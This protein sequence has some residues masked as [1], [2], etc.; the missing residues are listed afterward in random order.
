MRVSKRTQGSGDAAGE[1]AEDGG[2]VAEVKRLGNDGVVPD[3]F[4]PGP[5]MVVAVRTTMGEWG[6]GR[7][8]YA[9]ANCQPS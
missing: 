4:V 6:L 7:V 2:E 1:A 8:R 5:R 3:L 9:S